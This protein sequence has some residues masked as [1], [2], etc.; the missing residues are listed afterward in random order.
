[1]QSSDQTSLAFSI[2]NFVKSNL[3]FLGLHSGSTVVASRKSESVGLE[4]AGSARAPLE[5]TSTENEPGRWPKGCVRKF[6][7][8]WKGLFSKSS[9]P[10]N[11]TNENIYE[12]ITVSK[13]TVSHYITEKL[14]YFWNY[15]ARDRIVGENEL[16]DIWLTG[17][18][19]VSDR[20]KVGLDGECHPTYCWSVIGYERLALSRYILAP[21][22]TK[23]RGQISED[24]WFFNLKNNVCLNFEEKS[25]NYSQ[26]VSFDYLVWW[27]ETVDVLKLCPWLVECFTF[28]SYF[29]IVS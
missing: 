26:N 25:H 23:W 29:A 9:Y 24:H 21:T 1:M 12:E 18:R 11:I 7:K 28:S 27:I 16:C 5:C 22:A 19:S 14:K 6:W 17:F 15:F 4:S 8:I 10:R 3:I 20:K 2:K 13:I